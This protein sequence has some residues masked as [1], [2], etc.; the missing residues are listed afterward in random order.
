MIQLGWKAFTPK[1]RNKTIPVYRG[2]ALLPG[3][4]HNVYSVK[5][6]TNKWVQKVRIQHKHTVFFF[7][8][9]IFWLRWVF[10]AVHGLSL[11]A[12]SGG[13]SSLRY[14]GFSLHWL[15]LLQS[16]G[17]RRLGFRSCGAWALDCR[18]S[19]CGAQ[20]E[21][22]AACGIF[23]TRARTGVPWIG[24]QPL[25]CATREVPTSLI[26]TVFL[27][28][29]A[30]FPFAHL[31]LY[32]SV[33]KFF[34]VGLHLL[35]DLLLVIFCCHCKWDFLFPLYSLASCSLNI[36]KLLIYVYFC[37]LLPYWVLLL[38]IVNF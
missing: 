3:K 25:Y 27:S 37:T 5:T 36:W 14:T 6:R 24:R 32:P 10:V 12:V 9:F 8:V 4:S 19:S 18:L 38:F 28:E 21:L 7:N 29:N 31:I 1:W 33:L 35:L 11:V 22:L 34:H 16:T 2:H 23:W 13:Y 20:A 15:L 30:I 26:M 17:S